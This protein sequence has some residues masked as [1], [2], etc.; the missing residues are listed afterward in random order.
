MC[1]FIE[2]SIIIIDISLIYVYNE[3]I[4]EVKIMSVEE[5]LKQLILDRYKSVREFTQRINMSYS[6]LDS[7]LKRGVANSSI[8]NVVKICRALDISADALADGKII[9]IYTYTN[10]NL[11]PISIELTEISQNLRNQAVHNPR[12]TIDGVE[13]DPE[14]LTSLISAIESVINGA[15]VKNNNNKNNNKIITK[16]IK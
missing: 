8:N 2:I 12:T 1:T 13:T 15:N 4:K 10:N 5:K 14:I 3:I 11:C 9:D 16:T 6:T 7:I